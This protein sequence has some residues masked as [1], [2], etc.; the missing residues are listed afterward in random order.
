MAVGFPNTMN[1]PDKI[2]RE[3]Q[4]KEKRNSKKQGL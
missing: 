4:G 2:L 3:N 1:L